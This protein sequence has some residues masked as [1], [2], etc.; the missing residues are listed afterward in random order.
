MWYNINRTGRL[1]NRL[2]SRAHIYAAAL[3]LG[4][5]VIDWGLNDYKNYFPNCAKSKLPIY[6]LK[7]NHLPNY[8]N[9]FLAN[10]TPLN[11]INKLRPRITGEIGNFWNQS[12]GKGNPELMRIDT[13]KFR[14]F[15]NRH[16]TIFLN[17][18]KLRCNSWVKNHRNEICKYF[19]IHDSYYYKWKKLISIWKKEYSEIIG[20]HM[21]RGDFKTAMRGDYYLS[22]S[23]YAFILKN[24]VDI[25]F[26][27][28]LIIL[29]SED[30]F[31]NQEWENLNNSFSFTNFIVNN[32]SILDD[33]TGLIF[34]D[35]II[36]PKTSTFSK[37]AA[38]YGNKIW[39][40]LGR[41]SLTD[42]LQLEF[43]KV[44]VP[45]DY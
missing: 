34:C 40:G 21:R 39:A 29:F 2:F 35:K 33:L 15:C 19:K 25:D 6:P 44:E 28:S 16:N 10:E 7:N 38:F 31:F 8:P 42:M 43:K 17:G 20:I 32:G 26:K 41:K 27:K 18:Y 11:I 12:Y 9:N 24:F 1:G 3:E 30:R 36:G 45:F 4:E 5:T 23:E 22:P 37:W 14:S 13:E